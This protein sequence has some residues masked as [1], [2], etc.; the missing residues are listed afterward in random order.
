M[1]V[2]EQGIG[3]EIL[4]GSMYRDLLNFFPN[5]IIETEPRLLTIFKRSFKSNN[6]IPYGS[7]TKNKKEVNKFDAIMYAG[8][9]GRLFRNDI[10][11]F[12]NNNFL[13]CD[14]IEIKKINKKLD[15]L[16]NRKKIG[17]SW[18][19]K[20]KSYGAD[21]S[22]DLEILKPIFNFDDCAFINLQYGETKNEINNFYKKTNIK[23]IN[24]DGVDLFNDFESI[25]SLLKNLDLFIS[26]SNSTAH[27]AGALGVPTWVIKPKEHAVFHYWNQPTS[28]T[29]WYK[30]IKL[31]N[32]QNNWEDTVLDIKRN[33]IDFFRSNS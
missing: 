2:K 29:P 11:D 19:S 20:N 22:L 23:I 14:P 28:T 5:T 13:F 27:L 31:F 18:R 16:K 21:K 12:S 17:I 32:Y 4:Y 33:L 30:S 1:V 15:Y 6:F 25:G 26:V 24:I 7:V 8:S 10:K 9:L 3:D